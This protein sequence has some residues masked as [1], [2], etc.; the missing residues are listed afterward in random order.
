MLIYF[1]VF[2]FFLANW[3]SKFV[4]SVVINILQIEGSELVNQRQNL[5]IQNPRT[6]LQIILKE[7]RNRQIRRI[8]EQLGHPVLALHRVAI[9]SISLTSLKFGEYRLLS[10]REIKKL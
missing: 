9:A 3:K 4:F 5:R 1:I 6:Q 10:D 7:G 8:A 2:Q